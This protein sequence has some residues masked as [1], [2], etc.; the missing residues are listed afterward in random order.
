[1]QTGGAEPELRARLAEGWAEAEAEEARE[2]VVE[3]LLMAHTQE[4]QRRRHA[5]VSNA[6]EA[7]AEPEAV[8]DGIATSFRS[9]S[10]SDVVTLDERQGTTSTDPTSNLPRG[11]HLPVWSSLS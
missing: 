8:G 7:D 2:A 3:T 11:L 1:M 10:P 9:P 6:E 5:A 4:R